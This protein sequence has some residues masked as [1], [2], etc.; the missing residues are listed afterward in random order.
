MNEMSSDPDL[1][2][3]GE[4]PRDRREESLGDDGDRVEARRGWAPPR[5]G[6]TA[7]AIFVAFI[8]AGALLALYAWDLP[9]FRRHG[10]LATSGDSGLAGLLALISGGMEGRPPRFGY[11]RT[12]MASRS[13]VRLKGSKSLRFRGK[14]QLR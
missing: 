9:P 12:S 2:P 10:R 3:H 13:S 8:V 6:P 14:G 4:R 1:S 5:G 11:D 7:T